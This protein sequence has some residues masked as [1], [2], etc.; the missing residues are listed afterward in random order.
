MRCI[1]ALRVRDYSAQRPVPFF[2]VQG[3]LTI[4]GSSAVAKA[5]IMDQGLN[6]YHDVTEGE[7][8][9]PFS[10]I[11]MIMIEAIGCNGR[12]TQ[13]SYS[14]FLNPYHDND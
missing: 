8:D 12:G 2:C 11:F 3:E 5:E 6:H 9:F 4:L 7:P 1:F 10:I 14:L 13:F